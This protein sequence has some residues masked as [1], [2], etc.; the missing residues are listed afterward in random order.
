MALELFGDWGF[1]GGENKTPD[2]YQDAQTCINF[3]P[4]VSPNPTS[5]TAIALLGAPGLIQI[6]A[7]AGGIHSTG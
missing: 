2:Q 6:A 4:E 3:Y 7:G 1:A 5:K